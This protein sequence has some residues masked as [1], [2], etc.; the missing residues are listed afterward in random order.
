MTTFAGT[1]ARV[2]AVNASA[3]GIVEELARAKDLASLGEIFAARISPLGFLNAGYLRIFG[4]RQF[5]G[6]KYLFGGTTPGW[7][8]RYQQQ[9]FWVDDPVVAQCCRSTAAFTLIEVAGRTDKGILI[10][11]ES[12]ALG[13]FDGFVSPIRAG[14]DEVGFVLLSSATSIEPSDRERFLIHGM[15]ETYARA[16]LALVPAEPEPRALTRREVECLNWVAVGRSDQ[17]ISMI[18]GLSAN[19]VHGHVESAKCKLDANSRAQ[20]VLR[21]VM[22]GIIRSDPSR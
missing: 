13:L 20:L 18:L 22:A 14:Y 16:G 1:E 6:A 7:S 19:T 12:R 4:A 10:L 17:Q 11:S 2:D 15:C 9:R 3:S 21:A 5:H 8:E